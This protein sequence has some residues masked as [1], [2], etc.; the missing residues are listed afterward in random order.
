MQVIGVTPTR[1]EEHL[2][3]KGFSWQSHV[4]E[5]RRI[6][7]DTNHRLAIR[8]NKQGWRARLDRSG[9]KSCDI[10]VSWALPR[11]V[12]IQTLGVLCRA[13]ALNDEQVAA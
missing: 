9:V 8:I 2:A 6:D 10:T 5:W 11:V 1:F 13:A 3:A 7:R 12:H 4:S